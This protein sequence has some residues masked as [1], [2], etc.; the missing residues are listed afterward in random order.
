[1]WDYQASAEGRRVNTLSLAQC[2]PFSSC[3][4][5]L[6]QSLSPSTCM[7][8]VNKFTSIWCSASFWKQYCR[9]K[10]WYAIYKSHLK[11]VSTILISM[12][13]FLWKHHH[14]QEVTVEH[15]GA[16]SLCYFLCVIHLLFVS[17]VFFRKEHVNG[18]T[19]HLNILKTSPKFNKKG[20]F[21]ESG[22]GQTCK[23]N[24]CTCDCC[25]SCHS[26]KCTTE[27]N[28]KGPE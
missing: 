28:F 9:T 4:S 11:S 18:D 3:C 5:Q 22:V 17:V 15:C 19:A 24:R 10:T 26:H 7:E 12:S 25:R 21:G 14:P 8:R 13:G 23:R 1:M 16:E 2:L 6:T 27:S 20:H